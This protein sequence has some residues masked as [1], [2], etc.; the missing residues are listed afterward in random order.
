MLEG[1]EVSLMINGINGG[2]AKHLA[3]GQNTMVVVA[4][5]SAN[6]AKSVQRAQRKEEREGEEEEKR[7][8]RRKKRRRE[9]VIMMLEPSTGSTHG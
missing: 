9:R 7:E 4:F 5:L 2:A 1:A 3:F 6:T 8:K